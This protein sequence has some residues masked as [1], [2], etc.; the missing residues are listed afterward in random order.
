MIPCGCGNLTCPYC[1]PVPANMGG[2]YYDK[3]LK[4]SFGQFNY[5]GVTFT[6]E[7][8]QAFLEWQKAMALEWK[9]KQKEK[10]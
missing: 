4:F 9:A 10:P 2:S 5:G 6:A 7:E 3:N 1:N 8:Y